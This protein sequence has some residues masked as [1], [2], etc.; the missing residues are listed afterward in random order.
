M[1]QEPWKYETLTAKLG[2][3]KRVL[4]TLRDEPND[5]ERSYCVNSFNALDAVATE[6]LM[7]V[8]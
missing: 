8:N 5:G 7:I 1:I 2:I 3:F 4:A 6:R